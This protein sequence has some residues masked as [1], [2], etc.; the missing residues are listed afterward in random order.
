MQALVF[1]ASTASISQT[2]VDGKTLYSDG[3]VHGVDEPALRRKARELAAAAVERAGLHDENVETT[4]TLY[5]N[6][7]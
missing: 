3:K 4:T 5:D 2:W 1:S 7:N 6:G